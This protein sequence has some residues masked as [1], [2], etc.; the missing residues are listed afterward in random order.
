MQVDLKVRVHTLKVKAPCMADLK[1]EILHI[2]GQ[3]MTHIHKSP[4][5]KGTEQ[6]P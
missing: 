2:S 1:A 3:E 4:N 6:V 5:S